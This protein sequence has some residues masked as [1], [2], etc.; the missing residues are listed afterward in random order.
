MRQYDIVAPKQDLSD[1]KQGRMISVDSKV[2]IL[3]MLPDNKALVC[4]YGNYQDSVVTD[5]NLLSDGK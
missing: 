1:R 2:V 3:D 4:R 5:L